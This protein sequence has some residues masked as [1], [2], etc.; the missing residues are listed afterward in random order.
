MSADW[1]KLLRAASDQGWRVERRTRHIWLWAPS[2]GTVSLP[3]S[4]GDHRAIHNCV[5]QMRRLGFFWRGRAGK[6]SAAQPVEVQAA[7]PDALTAVERALAADEAVYE[8]V[9]REQAPLSV[10]ELAV[11]T[12]LSRS[13]VQ[14]VAQA[15]EQAGFVRRAGFRAREKRGVRPEPVYEAAS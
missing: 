3:T 13:T 9:V 12:G 15:L 10:T 2:G 14:L 6:G 11:R 5:A 8:A 1:D 7:E 4:T